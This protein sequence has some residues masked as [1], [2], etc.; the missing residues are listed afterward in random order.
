MVTF[1]L[2]FSYQQ[3]APRLVKPDS[4]TFDDMRIRVLLWILFGV[5]TQSWSQ[6]R[7]D[8]YALGVDGV[9]EVE[10][11]NFKEAI[12]LLKQARR[13]EPKQYDYAFE[14]GRAYYMS[15]DMRMA[16]KHLYPLQY[17][18]DVQPDLY[19]L[20][21]K[22]YREL[23]ENR[24]VPD[25]ERKKELDALRYGIQKLPLSGQLYLELGSRKLQMEEPI[26]AL[27]VFENGIINAPNFAENYFWAAKLLKATGNHLWSWIYAEIFFNLSEDDEMRRTA[28]MLIS[29]TTEKVLANS[30]KA[31]PEK[32]DQELHFLL[33]SKCQ[34]DKSGWQRH[35][36]KRKCLLTEWNETEFPIS[37]LIDRME[38]LQSKG[39]LEPYLATIYL[40]S[41]KDAFLPWIA[42]NTAE[43]DA[44]IKWRFWN[45]ISFI[46]P[47][48]RL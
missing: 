15:G 25:E 23:N 22:C 20:L 35:L 33:E 11:G 28:A 38:L 3:N 32:M 10:A 14:I 27:T 31:E 44:Y 48:K 45:P 6:V 26:K 47:I 37:A 4:V 24:R 30:W 8:A 5:S 46:K 41:D 1:G 36:D 17:H 39:F 16:E 2:K 29:E 21:A 42:A 19:V 13:L 7:S 18:V 40:E 9:K 34:S 12:N 43:Y